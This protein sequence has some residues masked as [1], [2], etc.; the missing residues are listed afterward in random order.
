M[1]THIQHVFQKMEISSRTELSA[2]ALDAGSSWR[3]LPPPQ[4]VVVLFDDRGI[5]NMPGDQGVET[6][7]SG[8]VF[9]EVSFRETRRLG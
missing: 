5:A 1:K 6:G 2:T 4:T 3:L 8:P 9:N 7:S